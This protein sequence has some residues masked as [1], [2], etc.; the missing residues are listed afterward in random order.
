MPAL[1]RTVDRKKTSVC[2]EV[3]MNHYL[4]CKQ[5]SGKLHCC[6]YFVTKELKESHNPRKKT[7][8]ESQRVSSV[9]S[10]SEFTFLSELCSS[11]PSQD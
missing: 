8:C 11:I 2:Q 6:V 5:S 4:Q 10:L 9:S 7:I 3:Q 1:S